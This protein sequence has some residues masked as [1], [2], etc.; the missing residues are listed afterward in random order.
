MFSE[1]P[2]DAP[3]PGIQQV[4][5]SPLAIQLQNI[6]PVEII[7]KRFPMDKSVDLESIVPTAQ[8]QLLLN[9]PGIDPN[10]RQAQ[11]HLEVH[12]S[13]PEE[14]R[15]F[16]IQFKLVGIFTYTQEYQPAMVPHFLQQDS[17]SAMLPFARELLL[18]L[19]T[20]LQIP[21]IV[22]PLVQLASPPHTSATE[23]SNSSVE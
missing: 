4:P 22:L 10:A 23:E 21:M 9:D 13:F 15:P 3:L 7:T 5:L 20:R 12:V 2:E 1:Q 16:D 19:C 17:L 11:V 6:F 18:N 8:T 14:P